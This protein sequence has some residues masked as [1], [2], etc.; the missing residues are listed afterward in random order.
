MTEKKEVIILDTKIIKKT[1]TDLI[2][3]ENR[4]SSKSQSLSQD[5]L[6]TNWNVCVETGISV[7]FWTIIS[8]QNHFLNNQKKMVKKKE[9]SNKSKSWK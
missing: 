5:C 2:W 9:T 1:I 7:S 6:Q 4:L 3:I 8:S